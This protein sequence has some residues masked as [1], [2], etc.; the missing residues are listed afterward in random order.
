V[1]KNGDPSRHERSNFLS[2]LITGELDFY[3]TEPRVLCRQPATAAQS[4][5]KREP[6]TWIVVRFSTDKVTFRT[7]SYTV[8]QIPPVGRKTSWL[9]HRPFQPCLGSHAAKAWYCLRESIPVSRFA[10]SRPDL[11]HF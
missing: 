10:E 8:S 7:R 6:G 1:V 9:N 3:S 5:K 4:E 11:I 2:I